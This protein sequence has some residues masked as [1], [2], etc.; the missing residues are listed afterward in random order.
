MGTFV[1]KVD[2]KEK[3]QSIREKVRIM[4]R[5]TSI[6]WSNKYDG[7]INIDV[8]IDDA[9]RVDG[10]GTGVVKYVGPI[11]F[12]GGDKNVVGILMDQWHPSNGNGTIDNKQ[13]FESEEGRGYFAHPPEIVE[14]LGSTKLKNSMAI[15]DK[16]PAVG[17][18]V[19]LKDGQKGVVKY[20]GSTDFSDGQKMV[21][22][23]LQEWSANAIPGKE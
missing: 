6:D 18:V 12:L 4:A 9:V 23:E 14:N 16:T 11:D 2:K 13:Y 21:G 17:S 15:P 3:E 20:V 7:K 1:K 8:A 5:S 19:T 22:V 10:G